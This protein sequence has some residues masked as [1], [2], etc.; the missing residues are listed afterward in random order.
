MGKTENTY[1]VRL[2]NMN[3]RQLSL[4]LSRERRAILKKDIKVCGDLG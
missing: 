2:K 1:R 3:G 4:N